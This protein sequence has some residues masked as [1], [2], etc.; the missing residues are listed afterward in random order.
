MLSDEDAERLASGLNDV[1]NAAE[2]AGF[3]KTQADYDRG[4]ALVAQYGADAVFRAIGVAVGRPMEKRNWGYLAGILKKDPTG[5]ALEKPAGP[6]SETL[7]ERALTDAQKREQARSA[8][9]LR[10]EYD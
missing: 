6:A 1:L 10:G 7:Q 2:R 4:N 9:I 8:K 5:G 3:P